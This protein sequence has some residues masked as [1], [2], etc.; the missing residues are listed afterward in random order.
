MLFSFFDDVHY[1]GGI[2]K[3]ICKRKRTL[4]FP[5][6]TLDLSE[7]ETKGV[8]RTLLFT[9]KRLLFSCLMKEER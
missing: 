8:Q 2:R 7:F 6:W 9:I 3:A 1:K 5:H 4:R